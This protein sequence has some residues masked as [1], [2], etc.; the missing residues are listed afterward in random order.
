MR[1][2]E[3]LHQGGAG[4]AI[5]SVMRLPGLAC[6]SPAAALAVRRLPAGRDIERWRPI[7]LAR[8]T[9]S[10][11]DPVDASS[12]FQTPASRP[13][14]TRYRPITT[15]R[16]R[17]RTS[18]Y[19]FTTVALRL[20]IFTE[21]SEKRWTSIL[22][23]IIRGSGVLFCRSRFSGNFFLV[24]WLIFSHH[25]LALLTVFEKRSVTTD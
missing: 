11:L 21:Q 4:K 1:R 23:S 18:V 19:H 25:R 12:P 3:R 2:R 10:T 22:V 5:P 17:A 15:A 13:H 24:V 6:P 8:E 7:R 14:L 9:A 16:A 20:S